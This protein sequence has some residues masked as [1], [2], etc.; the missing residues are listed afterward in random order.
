[1]TEQPNSQPQPQSIDFGENNTFHGPVA[2]GDQEV[3]TLQ[4]VQ[5]PVAIN[6]QGSVTQIGTVVNN[7]KV[8]PSLRILGVIVV[9]ALVVVLIG[10]AFNADSSQKQT[11]TSQ[12]QGQ[13]LSTAV[14]VFVATP[15]PTDTP[16]ITPT[17]L[18]TLTPTPTPT[19]IKM[20]G[21]FN[22]VVA[23]FGE[24]D[25]QGAIQDSEAGQWLSRWLAQQLDLQ[26]ADSKLKYVVWHDQVNRPA[27]NPPIGIVADEAEAQAQMERFGATMLIYGTLDGTQ[28]PGALQ[29]NF[30]WRLPSLRDEPDAVTGRQRLGS[31][32]PILHLSDGLYTE[33]IESD[34]AM[35][36]RVS[37]LIWLSKGLAKDILGKHEEARNIFLDAKQKLDAEPN[38]VKGS[39][40]DGRQVLDYF[41]GREYLALH[42]LA[43]AEASFNQAIE[44]DGDYVNA[45]IGLGN[46]FFDKAS[47]YF[48]RQQPL[49]SGLSTCDGAIDGDQLAAIADQLPIT[50]SQALTATQQA[51][52]SYQTALDKAPGSAW[53][54]METVAQYMLG[55]GYR[56][57][58]DA[59]RLVGPANWPQASNDLIKAEALISPTLQAFGQ[60]QYYGFLAYAYFDLASAQRAKGAI[61]EGQARSASDVQQS[62]AYTDQALA[63][64]SS[65]LENYQQCSA[66]KSL[67]DGGVDYGVHSMQ[68]KIA[69]FC[70]GYEIFVGKRIG[71]LGGASG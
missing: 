34:P 40:P 21:A 48:I 17:P 67:T 65:A 38:N 19:P 51:V 9:V 60:D 13:D 22:V 45:H 52:D 58:G 1:M 66:Q 71:D 6:T 24:K 28:D 32:V 49:D 18:P 7:T 35:V 69:C 55:R 4:D 54:P 26:F 61:Y 37:I 15:T 36:R 41:L 70:E 14:A 8:P 31:S 39:E 42:Q 43:E 12:K 3:Y 64:Y 62:Q 63:A 20:G 44:Q 23:E 25:S 5:G 16:T 68:N 33:E 56:L 10:V 2:G 57:K 46:V 59:A 50:I 29:L 27:G 47:F 30:A 11:N 53:K